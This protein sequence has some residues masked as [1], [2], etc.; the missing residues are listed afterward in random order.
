MISTSSDRPLVAVLAP[1]LQMTVTTEAYGD[2]VDPTSCQLSNRRSI[3]M[4]MILQSLA[5]WS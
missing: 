1:D 3:S 2:D 4:P 5:G